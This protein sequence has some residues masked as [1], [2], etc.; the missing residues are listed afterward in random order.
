VSTTADS[1]FAGRRAGWFADRPLSVKFGILLAVV[2]LACGGI[3]VSMMVGNSSVRSATVELGRLEHAQELVL[4][5]DTR[6]SELKVV[7]FKALVRPNP[8]DQLSELAD[9]IATPQ[10]SSRSSPRSR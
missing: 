4:Q 3:L 8:V 6:A 10:A 5:L 7:G 2:V 9:D 1:S